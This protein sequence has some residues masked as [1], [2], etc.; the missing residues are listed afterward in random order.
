[1]KISKLSDEKLVPQWCISKNLSNLEAIDE[2]RLEK[3]SKNVNSENEITEECELIEKCASNK[4]TYYYNSN[5]DNKVISQL[6]EFSKLFNM[7]D[8]NFVKITLTS[9]VTNKNMIKTASTD[10]K[11]PTIEEKLKNVWSDPFRIEEK[12]NT[13][14][15]KKANWEQVTKQSTMK[16]SPSMNSGAVNSLKGGEDYNKNQ[17]HT[18]ARGQNSILN[19]NAI[20]EY[21]ED[22]TIDNRQKILDSKIARENAKKQDKIDREEKVIKSMDKNNIIPKGKIFHTDNAQMATN[23][24]SHQAK[25]GVYINC[26]PESIP[27]Q[28]QGEKIASNK[29]EEDNKRKTENVKWER[30]NS[31]S[32]SHISDSF[33]DSLKNA[34]GN[35]KKS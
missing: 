27:N 6:R 19:P 8:D 13:D 33:A 7:N 2:K 4:Q 35:I 31:E 22:K 1:M 17:N 12:S 9:S 28:T 3:I 32:S 25:S 20:K 15:M 11:E 23:L 34:L 10:K 24:N 14:Y 18:V 5:W 29:K 30:V 26:D 21:A 16:E